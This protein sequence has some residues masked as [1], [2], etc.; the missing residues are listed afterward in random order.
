MAGNNDA[1]DIFLTFCRICEIPQEEITAA[2]DKIT[3]KTLLDFSQ[4]LVNEAKSSGSQTASL[5]KLVNAKGGEGEKALQEFVQSVSPDQR[6]SAS[7]KLLSILATNLKDFY[8]SL[9]QGKT[10]EQKQ[11]INAFLQSKEEK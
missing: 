7:A 11:V 9:Y 4:W 3:K 10:L 1:P 5:Q 8:D 2:W 6:Q